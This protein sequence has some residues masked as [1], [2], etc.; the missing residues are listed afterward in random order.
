[1]PLSPIDIIKAINLEPINEAERERYAA[2]WIDLEN[3]IGREKG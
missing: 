3:E 1:M 2:K